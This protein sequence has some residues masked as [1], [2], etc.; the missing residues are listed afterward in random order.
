MPT[1]EIVA[2]FYSIAKYH[3]PSREE[4]H[5][6]RLYFDATPVTVG[7]ETTFTTYVDTAHPGGWTLAEIWSEVVSRAS[8]DG[9]MGQ[10]LFDEVEMWAAAAGVNTFL[11]FDPDDYSGIVGGVSVGAA[12]AYLMWVF[13]SADRHQFRL[14]FMDSINPAPQRFA[15]AAPPSVDDGSLEWLFINSVIGFVTNDDLD[16]KI[17]ASVNS[18]YNRKLARSY[19]REVAP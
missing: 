2:P 7:T 17:A 3:T 11:G 14:T 1:N 6:V 19:G 9:G 13:K 8:V 10:L 16:I 4:G 5:H 18:G 12:A 15:I